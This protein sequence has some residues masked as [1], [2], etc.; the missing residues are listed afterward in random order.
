MRL[1]REIYMEDKKALLKVLNCSKEKLASY[2]RMEHEEV[3]HELTPKLFEFRGNKLLNG[4]IELFDNV[5]YYK[6][7]LHLISDASIINVSDGLDTTCLEDFDRDVI[8]D[9][10]INDNPICIKLWKRNFP[11]IV[12]DKKYG[13]TLVVYNGTEALYGATFNTT[14]KLLK[15]FI[16]PNKKCV[17]C[18]DC[19]MTSSHNAYIRPRRRPACCFDTIGATPL[20]IVGIM[21]EAVKAYQSRASIKPGSSSKA[22]RN[23][24]GV[25]IAHTDSDSDTEKVMP[26]FQYVKEYEPSKPYVYKGGH[27]KS[28]VSHPRSGYYRRSHCGSFIIQNGEFVEVPKGSGDYTYVRPTL[29]N[30]DKDSVVVN[31]LKGDKNV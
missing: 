19:A 16:D 7:C 10:T 9:T 22:T 8:L 23:Y 25:M 21:V 20:E 14:E 2:I 13:W 18:N 6:R 15:V 4:N 24:S 31:V 30:P 1:S 3:L 5:Y 12:G 27:H 11:F 26:L 17:G 29:V 28:P